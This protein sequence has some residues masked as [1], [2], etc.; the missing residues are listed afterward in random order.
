MCEIRIDCS[1]CISLARK[2]P[3]AAAVCGHTTATLADWL[4]W[5]WKLEEND[6][7]DEE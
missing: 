1:K 3:L 2:Q 5:I 4:Q 6:R 7:N